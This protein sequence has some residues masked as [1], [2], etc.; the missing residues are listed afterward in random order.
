MEVIAQM[1][2]V[3][4]DQNVYK[5]FA[6]KIEIIDP[7]KVLGEVT[8][9]DD[10]PVPEEELY[11]RASD[12]DV[13]I[14][15]IHQLRN[16]LIERFRNLKLIQFMGIGYRNYMDED[17]CASRG[18]KALGIG[19]YGSNAVAE[20][21]L[22]LALSLLRG[23]CEADRRLKREVWDMQGLLGGEI[24]G[25]T[26]GIVGTGAIGRLVAQKATLLGA[27]VIAHDLVV[28]RKLVDEFGVEYVDLP[29]LFRNSDVVSCHLTYT[30]ATEKLVSRDLLSSMKPEAFFVNTSRAQVVDY[31]AL[32]E[33]LKD[34]RIRGAALD[35][36]MSEPPE[37]YS[38]AKLEN[39]IATPHL[40]YYTEKA[41][42]NQ[43]RKVVESVVA[44]IGK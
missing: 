31:G 18:I 33:L 21:A 16:G 43:L 10:I 38:L 11:S 23:I 36:H 12:A 9:F 1:K 26:F 4:I 2:I 27:R 34:R 28:N 37:D 5:D 14:L 3:F 32:Y 13:I 8:A 6:H 44:N 22:G 41:L 7:L 30:K 25:S 19:E 42:E 17:F 20:Y 15:S 29:T 39:V 24:A 35:V 40:G